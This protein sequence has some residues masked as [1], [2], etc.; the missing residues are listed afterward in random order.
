MSR[1]DGR[2]RVLRRCRKVSHSVAEVLVLDNCDN[3]TP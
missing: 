1:I 2:D 3:S